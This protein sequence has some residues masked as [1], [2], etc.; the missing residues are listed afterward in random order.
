MTLLVDVGSNGNDLDGSSVA[1]IITITF[2]SF[3]TSGNSS[4]THL[5]LKIRGRKLFFFLLLCAA[6]DSLITSCFQ[7]AMLALRRQAAD[8]IRSHRDDFLPFIAADT[9]TNPEDGTEGKSPTVFLFDV[10]VSPIF[11]VIPGFFVVQN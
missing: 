6:L 5:L 9:D 1:I 8:H 11:S 10:H 3:E 7:A 2:W 4:S